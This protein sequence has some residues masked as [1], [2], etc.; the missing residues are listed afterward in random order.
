MF[1]KKKTEEENMLS[2]NYCLRLA[3][4]YLELVLRDLQKIE[5][6]GSE[7]RLSMDAVEDLLKL[8][9]AVHQKFKNT[10]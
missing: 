7:G 1:L 9:S 5:L 3:N 8:S 2:I 4:S 6:Q 10:K